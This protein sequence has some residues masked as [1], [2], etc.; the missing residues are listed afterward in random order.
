MEVDSGTGIDRS[1]V[2]A[3]PPMQH[4]DGPVLPI[5]SWP[6]DVL[7]I[8]SVKVTEIMGS[9][10]WP[11]RVYGIIAVRDSLDHK[12][13]VLF[14]RDRDNC[15]TLPSPQASITF[16]IFI[17][18]MIYY[19]STR[20]LPSLSLSLNI[21]TFR[22]GPSHTFLDSSLTL[23]GPSRAVVLINAVMF[24]VDLKVVI[25]HNNGGGS[26]WP[27]SE[28]ADD[29]V[30]SYNAFFYDNVAHMSNTGFARSSVESTEHSTMEFVFA[31]LTFAVEATIAVRVIEGSNH[32]RARLTARTAGIDEDVVLLDSGDS[33][34]TVV[35]DDNDSGP[36]V[37]LRRRVVVV[38]EKG[39]LILGVK[40][41]EIGSEEIVTRQVGIRPRHALR[42]RCGFNLGF[43]RMSI[44]IAWSVLP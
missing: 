37:A 28:E 27:E 43:C 34:V 11:L 4:T 5:S 30:L 12:R 32:F 13:N 26:P 33:K 10:Q 42:S 35:D 21:S 24:E 15:Q 2:T 22:T 41:A 40:A 36:L 44:M 8:F 7:Q 31:H 18:P 14:R 6:M 17:I 29:K 39:S 23:T 38:E 3:I 9:L 25:T 19:T 20:L 16:Y 1:T